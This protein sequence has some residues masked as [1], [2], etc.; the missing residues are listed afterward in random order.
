MPKPTTTSF[1]QAQTTRYFQLLNN[2]QFTAAQRQL[3][4]IKKKIQ[5]N[6]WNHGYYKALQ[7]MFLAQKT[8]NNQYTLLQNLNSQ[9]QASLQQHKREFQRHVESRFHEDFDRG[10]FSAWHDYTRLFL[11]T[12]KNETKPRDPNPKGQTSIAQYGQTIQKPER[13]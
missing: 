6:A 12:L 3:Q 9:D 4:R 5:K 10:F 11:K 1:P 13:R 2:R 8:N 7:G